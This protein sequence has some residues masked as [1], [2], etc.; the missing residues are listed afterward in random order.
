MIFFIVCLIIEFFM[1][2]QAP[3]RMEKPFMLACFLLAA[4]QVIYFFLMKGKT[5]SLKGIYL[6]HS[7]IFLL[8]F[9]IV[10]YQCDIDYVLGLID[11]NNKMLWIDTTIVSKALALS[12]LALTSLLLGYKIFRVNELQWRIA[13]KSNYHYICN[14]K[15][16]LCIL[17]Y[18]MFAFY[19]I[20]VPREYLYG[21]YNQGVGRGWVNIVLVLMQAVFLA[22][23]ALYCYDFKTGKTSKSY[24]EE[25]K[26]PLLLV[27]LY[28]IIVLVT[29]RR[30]E[31]V[32]AAL[33]LIITYSYSVGNKVSKKLIIV[34]F[35]IGA[36]LFSVVGLLRMGEA[37]SINEGVETI[38]AA[39]SF[40]PF[41]RELAGSVN[42]LHVAVSYFPNIIPYNNGITFFPSFF[43][44]VPGLDQFFQTYIVDSN[45]QLT[46]GQ[47]ITSL[48][49]GPT[50]TY[51][52]GS[53]NVADAY[54]SFGP[55][56][57]VVVFLLLGFFIRYLEVGSFCVAKSPLFLVLSF[58]CCSQFMFSCRGSVGIMFLSWSYATILVWFLTKRKKH[59]VIC[60]KS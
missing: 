42:T 56:G 60:K 5:Y 29:G 19:L 23:F 34:Y 33:L 27:F 49:L 35:V 46:S 45:V 20:F 28:I 50:G 9:F 51:G 54:I 30:T 24:I 43:I 40:S 15:Y 1:F 57:V 8:C 2:Q 55:I 14:S 16:L 52:M 31:A 26:Y 37:K 41:T 22:M 10:F 6:R 4:V 18:A 32:R 39:P 13:K 36:V 47:V 17:G 11:D 7:A 21:G 48:A 59:Q 25:L 53:S 3:N 38:S 44:L 12:N 58:G